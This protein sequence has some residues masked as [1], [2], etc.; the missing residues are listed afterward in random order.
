MSDDAYPRAVK[1][2]L[3]S[4]YDQYF[5]R[6][7]AHDAGSVLTD[8]ELLDIG[9]AAHEAI[10]HL[11]RAVPSD[12]QPRALSLALATVL[13]VSMQMFN[14]AMRAEAEG[15]DRRRRISPN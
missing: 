6:L 1:Q 8:D 9:M 13:R 2:V 7:E 3:A 4:A 10:V 5:D 14:L 12:A 11:V 15:A